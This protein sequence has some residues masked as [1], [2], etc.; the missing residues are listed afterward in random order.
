ML[1]VFVPT[2]FTVNSFMRW[3]GFTATNARLVLELMYLGLMHFRVPL[4]DGACHAHRVL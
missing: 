2:R 3:L 4:R 1:M